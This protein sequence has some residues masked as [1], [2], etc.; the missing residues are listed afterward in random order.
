[1]K[2]KF[3]KTWK[4]SK[5]Y[6]KDCLKSFLLHFICS[7][8]VPVFENSNFFKGLRVTKI[9]KQI[10][11][12]GA[13]DELEAISCFQRQ[14]WPKYIRQTLVLVWN[15]AFW[16]KFNC[17]FWTVFGLYVQTFN[18]GRDTR[19]KALILRRFWIFLIF[20]NFLRF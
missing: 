9:M 10:E 17:N 20:P 19:H 4:V 16:E 15:S 14:S 13:W 8:T 2:E 3:I 12:E 11:F 6:G 7:L 5:Y 18:F 1:M